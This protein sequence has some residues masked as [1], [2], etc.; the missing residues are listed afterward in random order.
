M[1]KR[2][3]ERDWK[4]KCEGYAWNVHPVEHINDL[5]YYKKLAEYEDLEE[6]GLLVKLPCKP[7]STVYSIHY[8]PLSKKSVIAEVENVDLFFLL[9]S[10]AENRFG[11]T[12]FLT[13]SEA[14]KKLREL[15][16]L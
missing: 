16:D 10:V 4:D 9:L 7:G 12:V 6:Q 1:S 11:K 8:L 15:E 2:L 5:C 13:Q 3:T 14:E